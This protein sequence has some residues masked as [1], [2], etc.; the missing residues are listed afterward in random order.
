MG[1]SVALFLEYKAKLLE[2]VSA[3]DSHLSLVHVEAILSA[4]AHYAVEVPIYYRLTRVRQLG[5]Y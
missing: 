1:V 5:G 2:T 3:G 4:V